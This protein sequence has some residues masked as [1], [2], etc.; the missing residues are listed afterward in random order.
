MD[1]HE[2]DKIV[3]SEFGT[4]R[5]ASSMPTIITV[6]LIAML[7]GLVAFQFWPGDTNRTAV[8]D[9]STRVE[10]APPTPPA[11]KPPSD[12]TQPVPKSAQ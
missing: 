4:R 11:E 10:R 1:E 6:A 2:R 8:T 5:P 3:R 7:V 12:L 9:S